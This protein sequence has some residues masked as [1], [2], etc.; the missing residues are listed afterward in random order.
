MVRIWG[1]ILENKHNEYKNNNSSFEKLLKGIS[2]LLLLVVVLLVLIYFKLDK[3]DKNFV[4]LSNNDSIEVNTTNEEYDDV[5]DV[6]IETTENISDTLPLYD[7]FSDTSTTIA[8][9]EDKQKQPT[10]T[11]TTTSPPDNSGKITYVIN[12]NSK[13][14]HYKNCSFVDRMKEENKTVVQLSKQEL[15]NYLNSGY[16]F[17]SSCG[18]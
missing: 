14:M 13:K 16:S 10:E 8:T 6:F 1:D 18:G 17:C 2:F 4:I 15:S 9:T 7:E 3:M 11:N 5:F 12:K